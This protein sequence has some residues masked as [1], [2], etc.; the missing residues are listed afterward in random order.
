MKIIDDLI[1]EKL[2]KLD[3]IIKIT[4]KDIKSTQLDLNKHNDKELMFCTLLHTLGELYIILA[5]AIADKI[6]LENY[7][8]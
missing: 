4:R 2:S 3:N 7:E 1:R 6:N 8:N 5:S